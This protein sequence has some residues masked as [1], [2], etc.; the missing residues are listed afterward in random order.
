M[1]VMLDA[2]K[3]GK[4]RF[5]GASFRNGKKNEERYPDGF[6]YDCARFFLD[7]AVLDS[8][9]LVYGALARKSEDMISSLARTGKGVIARGSVRR[10][11]ADFD[12][13][14]EKA[15]L[16]ELSRSGE[17]SNSFLI[18]FSLTHPGLSA[19]LIGTSSI[20]HLQANIFAAELGPLDQEVY[21]EAKKRLA[22]CGIQPG[23]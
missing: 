1:Q 22:A 4:I 11:R 9:M 15:R 5:I 19:V 20:S 12:E 2:K 8:I 18:R 3:A 17:D 16:R 13:L 6:G 14:Y 23:N 7:W 21:T 10:Y